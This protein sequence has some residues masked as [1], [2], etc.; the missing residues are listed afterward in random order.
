VNVNT[1][2]PPSIAKVIGIPTYNTPNIYTVS[3]RYGSIAEYFDDQLS[4]V[5]SPVIN[6]SKPL[7]PAWVKGGSTATLFL[8]DMPKPQH[9]KLNLWWIN[10][11]IFILAS[12]L[13]MVY[14]CQ[15]LRLIVKVSWTLLN[16]FADI[17][18]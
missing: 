5:N 16:F 13:R 15:S 9:G 14:C 2:S 12:K 11:G 3:F 10:S 1:H 18:N 4:S 8:T 17:L 6:T 7:L